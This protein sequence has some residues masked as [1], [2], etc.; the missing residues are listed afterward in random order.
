[1]S[2]PHLRPANIWRPPPNKTEPKDA[3][4]VTGRLCP[5][6][7]KPPFRFWCSTPPPSCAY[8]RTL[9]VPPIR[10][11]PPWN[12]NVSAWTSE[13]TDPTCAYAFPVSIMAKSANG[14]RY[15]DTLTPI[16]NPGAM[17]VFLSGLS[18]EPTLGM[19]TNA[20]TA[21]TPNDHPA[22]EYRMTA[23]FS[24]FAGFSVWA[25]TLT[26]IRC[27]NNKPSILEILIVISSVVSSCRPI[28]RLLKG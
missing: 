20:R 17:S 25:N 10:R 27:K 11:R 24:V 21:G 8:G 3:E 12:V 2:L 26:A 18:A 15:F 16:P 28:G 14:T 1:M 22:V 9:E 6:T 5:A 23:P 19:D 13:R 4:P 7:V